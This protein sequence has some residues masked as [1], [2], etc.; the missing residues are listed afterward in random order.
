MD[1]K[2]PSDTLGMTV[3]LVD[4]QNFG[5]EDYTY[6]GS[7]TTAGLQTFPLSEA[8]VVKFGNVGN[9]PGTVSGG[10]GGE[11]EIEIRGSGAGSIQL[12]GTAE[13]VGDPGVVSRLVFSALRDVTTPK[14]GVSG[15][16]SFD[17][18][19]HIRRRRFE[20]AGRD[21]LCCRRPDRHAVPV[22]TACGCLQ[23]T[24][25]RTILVRE[26]RRTPP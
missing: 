26:R 14:V 8:S 13:T 11:Y 24:S 12:A 25:Y 23:K 19:A 5:Y 18:A 15:H 20:S 6:T 7:V 3:K 1:V 9:P 4:Y 22:H 2:T 16:E 17:S 21:R 10:V